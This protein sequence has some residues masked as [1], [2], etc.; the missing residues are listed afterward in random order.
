MNKNKKK[1]VILFLGS[2]ATAG[3]G[4]VKNGKSLPTDQ[5]FFAEQ[6]GVYGI[7]KDWQ[8]KYPALKLCRDEIPEIKLPSLYQTWNHLFIFRGLARANL[9]DDKNLIQKFEELKNHT[10]P[11]DYKWRAEHYEHQFEAIR[12]GWS[13]LYYL[14][15]LAIWD[16]R[17]LIKDLYSDLKNSNG[18]F[19]TLKEKLNEDL[20]RSIVVNLN[21]DTTFDDYIENGF[22]PLQERELFCEKLDKKIIRPHGSLKWTSKCGFSLTKKDWIPP[23]DETFEDTHLRDQGYQRT[24]NTEELIFHQSLIVPSTYFKEEIIGNSTMPGLASQLL[25]NQWRHMEMALEQA[26]EIIFYGT[27]LAS[28]DDHLCFLIRNNVKSKKIRVIDRKKDENEKKD[29][30]E[31]KWKKRF[32][33]VEFDYIDL[34]Y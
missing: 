5:N 16:L 6:N 11:D 21:Y 3:S 27:S 17:V 28:G 1:E 32:K 18:A 8:K 25:W 4:M 31:K 19:K 22:S 34:K 13:K 10:W 26:E 23:W 14:A 20:N 2:G 7:I 9:C 29:C 15:E 24:S 12:L 33:M 30:F